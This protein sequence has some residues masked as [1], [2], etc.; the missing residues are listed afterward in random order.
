MVVVYRLS[1][2]M[3]AECKV[4]LKVI[5][6]GDAELAPHLNSVTLVCSSVC[7]LIR[8][9]QQPMSV[10]TRNQWQREGATADLGQRFLCSA[11]AQAVH[12][13]VLSFGACHGLDSPLHVCQASTIPT[14]C[15][16]S[17]IFAESAVR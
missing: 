1:V 2:D 16:P 17:P 7:S 15:A 14:L 10:V 13:R 8:E 4:V 12:R 5:R 11:A 3:I 9:Y 6:D